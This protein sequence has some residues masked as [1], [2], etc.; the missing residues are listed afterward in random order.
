[1]KLTVTIG[2][3]NRPEFIQKQVKNVLAQL[4]DGVSLVV[5]DNCSDIPVESLFMPAELDKFTI[6]R[7][8]VN[9]GRDQNQ[10]RCLEFVDGGWAWTLSDDDTIKSDA[11]KTALSLIEEYSDCC[12]INTCNKKNSLL[13]SFYELTDYFKIIGT[14]G[15]A[16]FQSE[17]LYNMSKLSNYI[18]WFNDFLSS[19]VGQICM[20][21]KYM[22]L[23]TG[24]KCLMWNGRLTC[25]VQP[26]GWDLLKFV[27]NS[28]ILIDKFDYDSNKLKSSLFKAIADMHLTNL[29][30]SKYS[31]TEKIR[32][33]RF[34]V[35]RHG[36]IN[37]LHYNFM[38]Y[39]GFLANI[40]MPTPLFFFVKN[41]VAMIYNKMKA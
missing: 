16:F 10:V 32:L 11:I 6:I 24:E 21:L 19:Q 22:E 39:L 17:C 26:G 20:V 14:F 31:K 4:V 15:N 25:E 2:T 3:Y 13:T 30:Y 29:T 23:N 18:F 33:L 38:T 5:F 12:Y 9:I 27:K 34:I 36:R 7:N 35:R 37:I 8:K 41:K 40:V 1:M 28:S